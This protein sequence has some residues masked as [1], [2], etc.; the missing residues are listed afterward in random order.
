MRHTRTYLWLVALVALMVLAAGA[1]END[2]TAGDD[3]D[4]EMEEPVAETGEPGPPKQSIEVVTAA[5]TKVEDAG[6]SAFELMGS[7]TVAGTSV[8]INAEGAFDY[9]GGDGEMSITTEVP[10]FGEVTLE[11]RVVDGV[12]YMDMGDIPGLGAVPGLAGGWISLDVSEAFGTD[13]VGN[14][15]GAQPS[16]TEQLD[17]L[18]AAGEVTE[19]GTEEVRGQETT[20]YTAVL[21]FE[22]LLDEGVDALGETLG[23]EDMAFFA[24]LFEDLGGGDMNVDVWINDDGFPVRYSATSSIDVSG[25]TVASDI[26]MEFFD[27]GIDVSPEAPPADEVTS[28]DDA[29]GGLDIPG[30]G[31]SGGDIVQ[32]PEGIQD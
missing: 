21:D 11:E 24:G 18:R 16:P 17:Q 1:C 6:S 27:F 8:D 3:E 14:T 29:F 28:F 19:V 15:L 31:G 7:S 10:G 13:G 23:A 32:V 22:A 30:L 20:H 12:V 9:T 2:S 4:E 5:A 26:T 25:Q